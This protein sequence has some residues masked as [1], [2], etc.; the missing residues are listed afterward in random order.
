MSP[1]YENCIFTPSSQVPVCCSRSSFEIAQELSLQKISQNADL[2][3][4]FV[5]NFGKVLKKRGFF[6]H[7]CKP[8]FRIRIGSAF[9]LGPWI[10]SR[11]AGIIPPKKEKIKKFQKSSL[12][13]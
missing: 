1:R 13:F 10:R 3:Q 5:E 2:G 11:Q 7:F 12:E 9:N 8:V 6:Y 4:N